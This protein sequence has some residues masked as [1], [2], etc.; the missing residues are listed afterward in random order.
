MVNFVNFLGGRIDYERPKTAC[1]KPNHV[2]LVCVQ[3]LCEC[4]ESRPFL[5]YR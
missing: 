5:Y 4:C 3:G 1:V 2:N